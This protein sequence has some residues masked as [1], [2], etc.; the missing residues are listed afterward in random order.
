[1]ERE[2]RLLITI[3]YNTVCYWR[4]LFHHCILQLQKFYLVLFKIFFV[5]INLLILLTIFLISFI[6]WCS[7]AS[8]WTSLK[9]DY[10]NFFV[11]PFIDLHFC[12]VV[13]KSSFSFFWLCPVWFFYDHYCLTLIPVHLKGQIPLSLYRL[14]LAGKDF[15]SVRSLGSHSSGVG[16]WSYGCCS[17]K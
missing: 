7:L 9:V 13:P 17:A 5:F 10:F 6:C 16:A 1:M 2:K 8:Y 3:S 12:G 15:F 11:R 14:V 4:F